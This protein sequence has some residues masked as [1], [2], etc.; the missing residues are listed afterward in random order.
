[1]SCLKRDNKENFKIAGN[2]RT[3]TDTSFA[4]F[5]NADVAISSLSL[6]SCFQQINQ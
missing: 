6:S 1:M 3:D 2:D 4:V 5:L